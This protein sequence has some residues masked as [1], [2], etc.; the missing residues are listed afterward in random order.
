LGQ[1]LW[2]LIFKPVLELPL[3]SICILKT[4]LEKFL[5]NFPAKIDH[6]VDQCEIFKEFNICTI[7]H[8]LINVSVNVGLKLGCKALLRITKIIVQ[9]EITLL[10][11]AAK[12]L[13]L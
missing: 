2:I 1:N 13:P 3:N 4:H 7:L 6:K 5:H 10:K 11:I 12:N 9:T 8:Q